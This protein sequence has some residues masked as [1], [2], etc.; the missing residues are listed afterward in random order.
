MPR[1]I[2]DLVDDATS[3]LGR[4]DDSVAEAWALTGL[5]IANM[6]VASAFQPSEA[7]SNAVLV[8]TSAQYYASYAAACP[9]LLLLDRVYNETDDNPMFALPFQ[10]L[11]NLL[12]RTAG[13]APRFYALHGTILHY[14][15]KPSGNTNL[16]IWYLANPTWL[17][18]DS[19]IPY[20]GFD[21]IY[22]VVA[23]QFTAA[24][25][26]EVE[27]ATFWQNLAGQFNLP[28]Q[29]ITNIRSEV[30]KEMPYV[31]IS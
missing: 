21:H 14:R 2:A 26:E 3:S 10:L 30:R 4:S 17:N 16:R 12:P 28:Q 6:V 23:N 27:T 13:E 25:A 29:A 18:T 22:Q 19:I 9:R 5:N 15:P 7:R 11:D 20:E 1:S 31:N 8:A 24:M